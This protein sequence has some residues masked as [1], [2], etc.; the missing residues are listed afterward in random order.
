MGQYHY[1]TNLDRK[2][3]LHP[4]KFGD[5]LKLLEFGCSADGIMTGLAVLLATSNGRGGGDL[6][7]EQ[8]D[9][10]TKEYKAESKRAEL[11]GEY[12]VGRWAG[13]RIAIIGDYHEEDDVPGFT[14]VMVAETG[15]YNQQAGDYS[16]PLVGDVP[17]NQ[18]AETTRINGEKIPARDLGWT[19]ISCLVIETME[20]DHYIK[21]QRHDPQ[22]DENGNIYTYPDGTPMTRAG[23]FGGRK[24]KPTCKLNDDGSI[25]RLTLD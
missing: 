9:P 16:A 11:L 5:G 1:V 20:L 4:H 3:F 7:I 12:I 10:Q 15:G 14:D 25:E 23:S 24:H 19:D 2:E 6:Q 18:N 22:K 21:S 13:D 17:W 8:Y